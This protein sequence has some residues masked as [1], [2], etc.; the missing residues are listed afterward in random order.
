MT[1][2]RRGDTLIPIAAAAQ[3]TGFSTGTIYRWART[4]RIPA[5][6]IGRTL[7]FSQHALDQWIASQQ[8][9]GT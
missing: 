4:G 3:Q 5:I 7:R 8:K 1:P 2:P 9:A 6:K